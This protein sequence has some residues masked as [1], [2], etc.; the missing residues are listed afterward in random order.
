M[1]AVAFSLAMIVVAT[2]VTVLVVSFTVS[3]WR[4]EGP[5]R[6]PSAARSAAPT[7]PRAG[8]R[9]VSR[10]LFVFRQRDS[11]A[12]DCTLVEAQGGIPPAMAPPPGLPFTLRLRAPD[13]QWFAN[14]V[15][16]LLTEWAADDRPL[17]LD[18]VESTGHIKATLTHGDSSVHLDL[19]GAAGFGAGL[20]RRPGRAG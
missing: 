17:V 16:E 12:L 15:E 4:D 6:P 9:L 20:R 7:P 1:G 18:L 5:V 3:G 11:I 10:L 14:R 19:A 13:T 2:A 8:L